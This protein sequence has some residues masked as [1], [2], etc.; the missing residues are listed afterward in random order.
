MHEEWGEVPRMGKFSMTM[1]DW[2]FVQVPDLTDVTGDAAG[3]QQRFMVAGAEKS[4]YFSKLVFCWIAGSQLEW[5]QRE[6]SV[7][8]RES[9]QA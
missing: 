5:E 8:A 9:L 7:L 4:H 1:Q 2:F 3:Q 6:F